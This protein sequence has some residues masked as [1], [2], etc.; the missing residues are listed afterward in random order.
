MSL[1]DRL[2]PK[3]KHSDPVV[4]E[5][6]VRRLSDQRLLAQIATD[7]AHERVRL[8][9]VQTLA[10]QTALRRIA[11][12]RSTLASRALDRLTDPAQIVIVGETAALRDVR[13]VAVDRI[14]DGVTLD[15]IA[16]R[17]PDARIRARARSR[18]SGVDQARN[19]IREVLLKL[20][21]STHREAGTMEFSGTLEEMCGALLRDPRFYINGG[22][23]AENGATANNAAAPAAGTVAQF[24]AQQRTAAERTAAAE[25]A[26]RF[27]QILVWRLADDVFGG[28]VEEKRREVMRDA[29]A[30]SRVARGSALDSL[31]SNDSGASGRDGA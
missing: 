25:A 2:R 15:R 14:Q 30:W 4:R 31:I 22:G 17:D 13:E 11:C 10:D 12:S 24:L 7:D 26:M 8:S 1:L 19:F 3:W 20:Q 23:I 16:G 27:F 18:S 6:A 28:R 9:A 5:A 29:A 21:V